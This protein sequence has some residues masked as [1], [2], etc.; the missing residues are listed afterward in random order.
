MA[1]E[2]QQIYAVVKLIPKGRVMSYA[3]VARQCGRPGAQRVVG[4]AMFALTE[5]S[6]VPWWRV[7]NAQ[8]RISNSSTADAPDRQRDRLRAEGVEVSEAYRV[9]MKTYDAEDLVYAKLRA[10]QRKKRQKAD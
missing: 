6:K 9:D 1:L 4:Y 5:G 7:I 3:G 10:K 8:G 2:F